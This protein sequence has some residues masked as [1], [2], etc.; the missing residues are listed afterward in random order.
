MES[1]LRRG[2]L[3]ALCLASFL[4]LLSPATARPLAAAE[5]ARPLTPHE[6]R[7]AAQVGF[8]PD[9]LIAIREEARNVLHRL[10]GYDEKGFQIL[11]PG[12]VVSVPQARTDAVLAAFRAKLRPRGYLAFRVEINDAIKSD[13]IG[14]IRG[15]DPYEILRIMSTNG[16][17]DDI[18]AEDIVDQLHVWEKR[19]PFEIIGADNDWVEIEF[20]TV[21]GD[22]KTL[23]EEVSDF[24][25]DAIDDGPGSVAA[26]VRQIKATRRLLLRW[27]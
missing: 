8:D 18:S 20:R 13:K 16:D 5:D 12:V 21:P 26:L 25:P 4:L 27:D 7:L 15:T 24:S 11:A 14:V 2:R 3:Q 9:V 1:R 17:E 19:D 6:Q 10:I 23:A 22:V